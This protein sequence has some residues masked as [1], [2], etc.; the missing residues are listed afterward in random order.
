MVVFNVGDRVVVVRSVGNFGPP[1]G[2]TGT[3][4]ESAGNRAPDNWS[5]LCVDWDAWGGTAGPWA[6]MRFQKLPSDPA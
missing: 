2:A 3:V 1:V 6:R 4:A 5:P